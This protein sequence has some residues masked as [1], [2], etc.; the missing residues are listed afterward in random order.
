[1]RQERDVVLR[2]K[3]GNMDKVSEK[4][5]QA[6]KNS[7][8]RE[9]AKK[10]SMRKTKTTAGILA[11]AKRLAPMYIW[12]PLI[13]EFVFNTAVYTGAKIIAGGWYHYNIETKLDLMIPFLP[14]TIIIYFGC[15]LFWA[16]NYVL[17]VR[18][19]ASS[20]WRFLSADFLA[21]CVCLFFF[22]VFPTTNTRPEVPGS[23]VWDV[24]M[25]FLYRVDTADNLFPSIHCLTSWFCFIGIRGKK[26][27]PKGY[28]IFSCLMAV[29]VFVSTLTTKQH[30]LYDVVAGMLLAEVS[31]VL[32]VKTG[33]VKKYQSFF[34]WVDNTLHLKQKPGRV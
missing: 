11:A 2:E 24:L 8:V 14:W 27:I 4:E 10:S 20:A 33:F 3:E 7:T 17:S 30:V 9:S 22:L 32:T 1:M 31:Y 34:E 6:K 12:F 5:K 18:G 23:S 15:Y 21:K 25:R 29:A 26:E 19:D 16:V 13:F 28:R